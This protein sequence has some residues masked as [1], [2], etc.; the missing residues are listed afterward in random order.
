MKFRS[1]A[2]NALAI[3]STASDP[4]VHPHQEDFRLEFSIFRVRRFRVFRVFRGSSLFELLEEDHIRL[5]ERKGREAAMGKIPPHDVR[6][7]TGEIITVRSAVPDDAT[8]LLTLGRAIIAEGEFSVT[9]PEEYTFTDEQ[10]REWIRRYID[11]SGKLVIAA[12][13]S[14]RIIGVL[15]LES[16]SRKR[17]AHVATLHMSVAKEWRS[18]G[19]G[20]VLLQSAID[21]AQSHPVIEKLGLAVFSSNSR[22]IGLYRKLEFVE[23]GRRPREI[24]FGPDHYVDDV[25]MCR[26]VKTPFAP[27]QT[28][29]S[30]PLR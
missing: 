10:E 6:L 1:L 27:P 18:R 19:V 24:K 15:F 29:P 30:A 28:T 22:A 21:W 23:E 25:L 16:G 7:K 17:L 12:E 13:E 3:R 14:G 4:T 2:T 9:T 26:F 11:D 20:T 8:D 5:Y